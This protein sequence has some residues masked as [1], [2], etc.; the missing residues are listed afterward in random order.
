[1]KY[2]LVMLSTPRCV[3]SIASIHVYSTIALCPIDSGGM[4]E[5]IKAACGSLRPAT[6][7]IGMT[8]HIR[9]RGAD[10]Y[11]PRYILVKDSHPLGIAA[12]RYVV[13]VDSVQSGQTLAPDH[14]Q[15]SLLRR[16]CRACS[17]RFCQHAYTL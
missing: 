15:A 16:K 9:R 7:S 3:V 4:A 17:L 2:F 8:P 10:A 11:N 14:P 6:E 12:C 5:G 13:P 1:M